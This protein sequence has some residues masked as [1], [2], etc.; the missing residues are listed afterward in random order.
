[1]LNVPVHTIVITKN[2]HNYMQVTL[3]QTLILTLTV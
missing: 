2:I 3:K 1:M